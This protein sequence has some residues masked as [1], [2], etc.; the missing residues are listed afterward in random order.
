MKSIKKFSIGLI[1][2]TSVL[3]QNT[4]ASTYPSAGMGVDNSSTTSSTATNSSSSMP[5]N[6][7][8]APATISAI[9]GGTGTFD[10]PY[11]ATD[12]DGPEYA[13]INGDGTTETYLILA[14]GGGFKVDDY[15]RTSTGNLYKLESS[16]ITGYLKAVKQ[17]GTGD[18]T[19]LGIANS[20]FLMPI[21]NGNIILIVLAIAY[22][23]YLYYRRKKK[24]SVIN[25]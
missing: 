21:G 3:S 1:I 18:D 15:I 19:A 17:S 14:A 2:V 6:G 16:P 13:D 4:V 20:Y 24:E 9:L 10:S 11:E 25:K 8:V 12:L 23:G 22:G 5:S 7:Y